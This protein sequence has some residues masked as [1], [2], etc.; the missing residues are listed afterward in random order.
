MTE[1]IALIVDSGADVPP[2]VL[3][4]HPN[5]AVVPLT[6]RLNGQEYRDNVDLTPDE[7]Y[8][9]LS[10]QRLP[11]TASPAPA[12]V[13][14][15]LE[16]L[17]A[18]GYTRVLGITIAS[19]LSATYQTF[20]LASS[21]FAEGQVMV[22]DSK[23]AGIGTG[24]V[25]AQAAAL[26]AA[27]LDFP[28]VI[29]GTQAAIAHSHVYLYLPTLTYLQ[30]GG[31]IGRVA[32]TLG[33][34]LNIKPLLTVNEQ[35]EITP[36]AKV[37]SEKKTVAKLIDVAIAAARPDAVIAVAH[38]ANPALLHSVTQQIQAAGR[39]V[40]YVGSVSPAIGA[41]TGP[42]LIGVAVGQSKSN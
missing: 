7:F 32:G 12:T 39:P 37:R 5:I 29:A 16:V 22:L 33:T 25:V 9:A 31:R 30:A 28:A 13:T 20:R 23:S 24:L 15:T 35:G 34:A 4:A 11:Q 3:A 14:G 38:G 1:K 40:T 36:I 41:H 6:V 8:A 18:A 10:A 21:E 27:G 17:F 2:A 42:G 19:A 26:I